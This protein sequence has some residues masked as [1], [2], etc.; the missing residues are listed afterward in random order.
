MNTS[1]KLSSTIELETATSFINDMI[2]QKKTWKKYRYVAVWTN[3]NTGEVYKVTNTSLGQFKKYIKNLTTGSGAWDNYD[4]ERGH[5]CRGFVSHFPEDVYIDIDIE[6]HNRSVEADST[7]QAF[8]EMY[9]PKV[10]RQMPTPPSIAKLISN[11]EY[12]VQAQKEVARKH[13]YDVMHLA[14]A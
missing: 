14:T 1:I 10:R 8:K 13:R 11:N 6:I 7:A 3:R 4:S 12:L 2:K 9:E 5:F